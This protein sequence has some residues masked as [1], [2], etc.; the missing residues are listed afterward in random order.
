MKRIL[1]IIPGFIPS[2]IIGILRPLAELERRGEIELRLRL[3]QVSVLL[4]RD[5][6]WCDAAVFCRNCETQDLIALYELK[7]KGK[8]IIY[9][10]DDNFEEISLE[11]EV[12]RYHRAFFRLHALSRFFSFADV[13]RVYS[14]G[15]QLRAQSHGAHTQLNKSYFD[16]SIIEGLARPKGDGVIRIA[17]PTS[18]IDDRALENILFG[19]ARVILDRYPGKVEF[20]LWRQSAPQ[21]LLGVNGIVLNEGTRGYENFIKGFYERGF[22][23][24]LA[25][26]IDTPFFHSKTNNKYREFGGCSIAGIYSNFPP[27]SNTITHEKTGLLVESSI[28]EWV[29]AIERLIFDTELRQK[30]SENALQDVARNYSFAGCVESW[31]ESFAGIENAP[32]KDIGWLP[33]GKPIANTAIIDLLGSEQV[34]P[35]TKFFVRAIDSLPWRQGSY[36]AFSDP[37]TY[38]NSAWKNQVCTTLFLVDNAFQFQTAI[39]LVPLSATSIID[40]SCYCDDTNAALSSIRE[41]SIHMPISVILSNEAKASSC[42]TFTDCFDIHGVDTTLPEVQHMFS[43]TGYPAAYLNLIEKSVRFSPIKTLGSSPLSKLLRRLW[44][45][46]L[47]QKQKTVTVT[48]LL[49]W[50]VGLRRF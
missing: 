32:V 8:K 50:R 46:L 44:H 39:S 41:L 19:A 43:L 5:I 23:I 47:S 4:S 20:H 42:S 1:I 3:S 14:A 18:R 28:D 9:E 10:V 11:T 35:R 33:E 2:T 17:Y 6:D 38:I 27:Y 29:K 36:I 37:I 12:G 34:S 22:D 40:L 31:R 30:I 15:L 16:A 24:G 26:G 21:E 25:P 49:R 48:E 7:Q 45:T 13:T